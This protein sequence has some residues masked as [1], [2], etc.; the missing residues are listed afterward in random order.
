MNNPQDWNGVDRRV[1]LE[2]VDPVM[3]ERRLGHIETNIAVVGTEV[4]N[5]TNAI[6]GF[7]DEVSAFRKE[8]HEATKPQ[9]K[10]YA[11]WAGVGISMVA[12]VAIAIGLYVAPIQERQDTML[13]RD[14]R[15]WE[16]INELEE[17]VN[18]REGV[19]ADYRDHL[20]RYHDIE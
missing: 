11:E 2:D 13:A 15:Q 16:R 17:I 1:H 9:K 20:A 3:L 8:L 7:K 6:S 4:V 14:E 12:T 18:R 19:I 5:L 10:N